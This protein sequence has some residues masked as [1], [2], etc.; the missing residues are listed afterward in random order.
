M[1]SLSLIAR[2]VMP[3]S[4]AIARCRFTD[5]SIIWAGMFAR[6]AKL[7]KNLKFFC[8]RQHSTPSWDLKLSF[9]HRKL[10]HC[11]VKGC[12]FKSYNRKNYRLHMR[13]GRHGDRPKRSPNAVNVEAMKATGAKWVQ[14]TDLEQWT[15]NLC[16]QPRWQPEKRMTPMNLS[17][18]SRSWES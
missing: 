1:W 12:W 3:S 10:L 8:D 18:R 7:N 17:G 2:I 9:Y 13:L 11:E 16:C 4:R 15:F 14:T 5:G 6:K